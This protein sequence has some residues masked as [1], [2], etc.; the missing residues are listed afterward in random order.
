M[1]TDD[2]SY[3]NNTSTT[4]KYKNTDTNNSVKNHTDIKHKYVRNL[5]FMD[6]FFAGYGFIIGA[7]IFTLISYS[8]TYGKGFTWLAFVIGGLICA[9]TGLGYAKLNTLY[10]TNDAEYAWILGVLGQNNKN[11][12]TNL[13][14]KQFANLVIWV[15]MLIGMFTAATV[16]VGQANFIQEYYKFSKPLLIAI[17]VL[18][19]TFVNSLGNEYTTGLNKGIM[20]TATIG[21]FM[22]YGI[23]LIKSKFFNQND[24]NPFIKPQQMHGYKAHEK[25][26]FYYH[27]FKNL[28]HSSF[29]TIFAYNGFQSVVQLS[30]EAKDPSNVPKSIMGSRG[31]STVIYA[32]VAISI[33]SLLGVKASS[34]AVNPISDAFSVAFGKRG[35]DIVNVIAIIC[36]TNTFLIATL[37]RSRLL[38]KLAERGIAPAVFKKLTSIKQI[39][40]LEKFTNNDVNNNK[41]DKHKITLPILS[42]ITVSLLT[43]LLTF[44]KKGAI[45]VLAKITSGFIFFI[46]SVVNLLVIVQYYKKKTPEE[47]EVFNKRENV[48]PF[49]KGFPWYSILGIIITLYYLFMSPKYL[50][51]LK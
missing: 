51:S 43:Y 33:I 2:N 16:V 8:L 11:E 37:S 32:L 22:L 45:E 15:V 21:F 19:P 35:K 36:L 7:G 39:L 10:P 42:I 28:T 50:A 44:I 4:I 9:L 20:I 6:L 12:T 23:G 3:T 30:E 31:F 49:I 34:N 38:Q 5:S 13:L 25:K 24:F 18:I 40:G 46:F 29:I 41:I 26:S 14:I 48:V 1:I 47:I 27:L 17:L